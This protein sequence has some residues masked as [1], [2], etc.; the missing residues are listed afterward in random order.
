[1]LA[2]GFT[3]EQLVELVPAGLATAT[4]QRIRAGGKVMEVA[5]LRITEAGRYALA[6]QR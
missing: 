2:R 1:M 6:E 4:A 5:T 3:I